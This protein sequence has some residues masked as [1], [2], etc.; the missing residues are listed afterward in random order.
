MATT[1][2]VSFYWG[3]RYGEGVIR[4]VNRHAGA[5]GWSVRPYQQLRNSARTLKRMALD[6]VIAD[7]HTG[8]D[9]QVAL[10]LGVPVIDAGGTVAVQGISRVCTDE[11]AVGACAADYLLGK[12]CETLAFCGFADHDYSRRRLEGFRARLAEKGHAAPAVFEAPWYNPPGGPDPLEWLA[13]LPRPLGL[14][15]CSDVRAFSLFH[16]AEKDERADVLEGVTIVGVDYEQAQMEIFGHRF[17]SIE[18]DYEEIGR[19]AVEA[20][21]GLLDGSVEG[22]VVDNVEPLGVREAPGGDPGGSRDS[23]VERARALIRARA[24][25]LLHV[26]E[27]VTQ[28]GVSQTTLERRFRAQVGHSPQ[29][30]IQR[31]RFEKACEM[32]RNSQMSLKEIASLLGYEEQ[33]RLTY[34]FRSRTGLTPSQY[35]ERHAPVRS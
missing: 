17:A 25:S 18:P 2:L 11:E 10:S 23:L 13:G 21:A 3:M 20:L 6:G 30:E 35:R 22:P 28:L 4:A 33:R 1:V 32:L 19:R 16:A 31:L 12:P 14:F 15:C 34:L 9:V 5:R 24:L 27:L 26:E 8:E 29:E 7:L